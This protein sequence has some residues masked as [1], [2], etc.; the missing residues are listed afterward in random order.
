MLENF[1][2]DFWGSILP[3]RMPSL[4]PH[5]LCHEWSSSLQAPGIVETV[6]KR[7]NGKYSQE[8]IHAQSLDG[9]HTQ[10][11]FGVLETRLK[12]TGELESFKILLPMKET[13]ETQVQSLGW[14]D[15]LEEEM[16]THS[17]ILAYPWT[18]CALQIPWTEEPGG[19]HSMRLQRVIN[20]WACMKMHKYKIY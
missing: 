7:Q 16:A 8:S 12:P 19:L 15:P 10:F 13:Q 2:G 6:P 3:L 1:Q 18:R 9:A 5:D 11:S 14:E 20:D 17:S 4:L